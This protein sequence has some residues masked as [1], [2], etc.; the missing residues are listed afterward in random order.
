[1]FFV[2]DLRDAFAVVSVAVFVDAFFTDLGDFADACP[3][4][5][6]GFKAMLAAV[7]AAT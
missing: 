1:L 7:A 6:E 5:S 3:V 2:A 4:A